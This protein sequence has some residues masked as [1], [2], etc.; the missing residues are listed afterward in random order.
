VYRWRKNSINL[1][2]GGRI[3]GATT[4][5]LSITNVQTMDQANYDCIITNDCGTVTSAAAVLSCG[6]IIT[7][8]PVSQAMIVPGLHLSLSVP[9]GAVYTYR[10]RQNGQNLFNVP[11]VFSGAT[12]RTL[13]LIISDPSLAGTYDCVV[14]NSCGTVVSAAARVV[15]VADLDDGSATGLPDGGVGIED[16]LFYLGEYDRGTMR[17][18]VD[19]GSGTGA[20]DG[21][22]GIEDLLYYL[23][24]FDAGC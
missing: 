20:A 22:V 3:T 4:A 19:D 15:C 18:D 7:Q 5:S 6:P 17:A 13:T 24:R 12:T 14:T 10:W 16:L 2:D 8:Q 9:S 11:S 21:G 1:S 23:T